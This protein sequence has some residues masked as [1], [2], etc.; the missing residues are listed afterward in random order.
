MIFAIGGCREI[1][2][3]AASIAFEFLSGSV[4]QNHGRVHS[5]IDLPCLA[6]NQNSLS[7]F[8]GEL[9]ESRGVRFH[10]AVDECA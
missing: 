1:E 5:R 9:V 8:R 7:V 2:Q 10:M 6:L 3:A 4:I